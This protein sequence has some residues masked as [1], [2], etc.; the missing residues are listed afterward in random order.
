MWAASTLEVDGQPRPLA[1]DA[2]ALAAVMRDPDAVVDLGPMP[3]PA[4]VEDAPPQVRHTFRILTG[5][6]GDAMDVALGR[7]GDRWVIG[8]RAAAVTMRMTFHRHKRGWQ[9]TIR[10]VVGGADRSHE[11][12]DDLE[13]ALVLLTDAPRRPA[14]AAPVIGAPAEGKGFGSVDVRRHA[15]IRN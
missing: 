10:V 12:N 7:D 4:P 6:V 3:S 8:L 5:R 14:A 9:P 1:P 11:V 15:V 2:D 13:A